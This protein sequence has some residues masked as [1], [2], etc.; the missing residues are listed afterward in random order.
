LVTGS[1]Q[2]LGLAL[3]RRLAQD[4]GSDGVVYL[5]ARDEARGLA[6]VQSLKDEALSPKFHA[7]D[8]T[9][10][11]SVQACALDIAREHG[12]ID[13]VVSNAA[14]RI[15]KGQTPAAQIDHFLDTNNTGTHRMIRAFGP[16]MNDGARFVVV[17]S[18][19]GSLT[20]LDARLHHL[21]DTSIA[22]LDD[23]ERVMADYARLVH[24]GRAREAGWPE[25]INIP[26]K[27]AQVASMKIFAR[28]TA[29]EARRRGILINAVCPGLIDTEASRPWFDDMS[30]ARSPNAAAVDAAWVATLPPGTI[31]PYGQ[32]VRYRKL[33]PWL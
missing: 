25:W 29:R 15:T 27:I 20:H 5:T 17:A 19:F 21:F 31:E 13:I 7:L 24:A 6:A 1:N 2:G 12:G 26:S 10:D 8:V 14:A 23:I 30:K 22:T 11:Q 18:S 4:L 9:S 32:L 16:L 33:V 28:T 3:V